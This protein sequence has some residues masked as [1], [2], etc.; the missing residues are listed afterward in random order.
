MPEDVAQRAAYQQALAFHQRQQQQFQSAQ[1]AYVFASTV[2]EQAK[3]SNAPLEE[4][5]R[6]QQVAPL[7]LVP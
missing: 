4:Q 6:A 3:K 1:Q 2:L 7:S 5:Q